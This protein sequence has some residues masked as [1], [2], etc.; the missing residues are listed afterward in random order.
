MKLIDY[1]HGSGIEK[2]K[3]T[4]LII[5]IPNAIQ[6]FNF[7]RKLIFLTFTLIVVIKS[8][9]III[10]MDVEKVS[11]SNELWRVRF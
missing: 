9:L 10:T 11:M 2:K 5:K 7:K 4:K 1:A 3:S 6:I 8:S